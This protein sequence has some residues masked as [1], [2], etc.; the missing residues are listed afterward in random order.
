MTVVAERPM[1]I[2]PT[3]SSG[4]ER[5]RRD[6][7]T[8][9]AMPSAITLV[10][11]LVQHDLAAWSFDGS[12]IRRVE[13]VAEEL[14]RHAVAST[15]ITEDAPLYS[16]VFDDLRVIVVRLRAFDDRVIVEMWDQS[17]APPDPG[18]GEKPAIAAAERWAYDVPLPGRRVVWCAVVSLTPLPR[19][20]PR[21]IPP[22]D[23][24]AQADSAFDT[25]FLHR[26]LD[27]LHRHDP[28]G[29]FDGDQPAP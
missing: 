17:D 18:L 19:R 3:V 7:L 24:Q 29:W 5:E 10:R 28:A 21:A 1:T 2:S 4:H 11:L 14:A 16:A 27:G 12:F 15:G 13:A 26:V 9:A 23:P 20:T 8:L 25:G 22:P 6:E